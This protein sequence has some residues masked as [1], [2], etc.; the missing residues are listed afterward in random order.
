M[1]EKISFLKALV[2][3]GLLTEKDNKVM[4]MKRCLP[5]DKSE[6]RALFRK[7]YGYELIGSD[8]TPDLT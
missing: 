2:Q 3:H 5:S 8:G 6:L 4:E 1:G 7:E